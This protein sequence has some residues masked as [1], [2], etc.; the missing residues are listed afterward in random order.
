M[1][2]KINDVILHRSLIF[3]F[4]LLYVFVGYVSTLHSITFFQLSN[5]ITL[6]ILLACAFELG[7]AAV[8]FAILMTKNKDKFL[9]WALMILLTSLQITGNVYASFKFIANS[10]NTD[11]IYWYKSILIGVQASNPEMYQI[12]ISWISGALLPIVALG[13]TALVAENIK[14]MSEDEKTSELSY[15]S[16]DNKDNDITETSDLKK[17]VIKDPDEVTIDKVSDY[18]A[19]N[20]DSDEII[21][22][23]S[24]PNTLAY[25][26]NSEKKDIESLINSYKDKNID[27]NDE[28]DYFIP[29]SKIE[30]EIVSEAKGEEPDDSS[31][32]IEVKVLPDVKKDRPPK[33]K[34][35][36]TISKKESEPLQKEEVKVPQK[37]KR[38]RTINPLK[39]KVKLETIDLQDL[40]KPSKGDEVI[41]LI[42]ESNKQDEVDK[43]LIENES[44]QSSYLETG[45]EVIDA[46]A[47]PLKKNTVGR[48]NKFGVPIKPSE[49]RNFDRL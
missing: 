36:K 33:K 27:I 12:I 38:T 20:I 15:I 13:M 18:H 35:I 37:N 41:K 21:Q 6:S 28:V 8:L 45:V 32:K 16:N 31:K 43:S 1:K 3:I 30:S 14:L 5:S 23:E 26:E 9:P 42:E 48:V 2:F 49:R 7:Q 44:N 39:K 22:N 47:V 19:D 17:D 11:W 25:I 4:A 34:T 46:K 10:G 29:E 24:I 40:T